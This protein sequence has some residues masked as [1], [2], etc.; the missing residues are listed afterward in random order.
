MNALDAVI[1]GT[2]LLPISARPGDIKEVL[3]LRYSSAVVE[4]G[5]VLHDHPDVVKVKKVCS[6]LERVCAEV[7]SSLKESL[8]TLGEMDSCSN[9]VSS[10]S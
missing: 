8:R 4:L 1:S 2:S 7:V 6:T 10:M 3:F 9:S 5:F